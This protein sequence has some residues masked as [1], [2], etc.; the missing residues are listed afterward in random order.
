MCEISDFRVVINIL[1]YL[2]RLR[3]IL[4]SDAL[5]CVYP[6]LIYTMKTILLASG[7]L[8]SAY[9]RVYTIHASEVPFI[10][11]LAQWTF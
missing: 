7:T 6:L 4:T 3:V 9:K 11:N 2:F 1:L 10:R 8:E 5:R